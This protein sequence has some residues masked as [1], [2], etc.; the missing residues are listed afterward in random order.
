MD[1]QPQFNN[2]LKALGQ[3]QP[4]MDL[5]TRSDNYALFEKMM[6]EGVSLSSLIGRIDELEGKVRSMTETKPDVNV[7]ILAVMESAV[8]HHPDVIAARKKVSDVK[9]QIIM[10]MCKQ[11]PRFKEALDEYRTTVQSA[12]IASKEE[13]AEDREDA[14]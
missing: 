11:D 8:H 3:A 13:Q 14:P 7:E 10:E 1:T 12:Y 9:S 5:Q 6:K 2:I 4:Q